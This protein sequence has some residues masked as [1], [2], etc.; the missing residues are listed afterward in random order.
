[1]AGF[2]SPGDTYG[3]FPK[4]AVLPADI[5]QHCDE[6]SQADGIVIVHPNWWGL[7]AVAV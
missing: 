5:K 6:V 4:D 3:E 2:D 7:V 1:M